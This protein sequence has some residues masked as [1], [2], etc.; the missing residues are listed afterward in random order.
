[1]SDET[2]PLVADRAV[3]ATVSAPV[4]VGRG[5]MN[6]ERFEIAIG[7]DG[8]PP[9]T[10][11]RDVLRAAPVA[12]VL[13]ID[14]A[15][16]QVVLIHQFRLPAHFSTGR[17]EMVEIVAGRI[18]DGETPRDAA[19]RECVEEIGVAPSRLVDL[20]S[21]LPSPGITDESVTFFLG[22]VDASQVPQR[23]GL[24]HET[25]DTRPF[26]VSID[27]AVAALDRGT[28]ANA[29]LVTALQWLALH[30]HELQGYFNRAV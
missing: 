21:V 25:E 4:T 16:G 18:D 8:E 30:R 13:P 7:R 23:G 14:L 26:V 28:V 10:Q 29:L 9:L 24:D 3:D 6:Y 11:R 2:K 1:M 5:Y 20:F 27:D 15:R 12:A 17:G 22:F 19:S